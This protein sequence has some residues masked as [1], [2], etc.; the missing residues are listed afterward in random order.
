M[1]LRTRVAAVA[2]VGTVAG[3]AFT[4]VALADFPNF[5]DCPTSTDAPSCVDLQSTSGSLQVKNHRIDLG[6]SLEVRG[7]VAGD[8][9][10]VGPD[11]TSGLFSEPVEV[12]GGITGIAFP[13][14]LNR[15]TVELKVVEGGSVSFN[16]GTL[17]ITAPVN[18][19][20]KSP[21]LGSCSVGSKSD[22][23]QLDLTTGT[24]S[25]PAPNQPISGSTG[26][27]TFQDGYLEFDNASNVDNSFA[28]PGAK[29]CLANGL[30]NRALG[31]PSAAGNNTMVV[32][33][34]IAVTF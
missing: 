10:V 19:K 28:L 24:T 1:N 12:P 26:D 22:P 13:S 32:N 5:S 21:L 17:D 3:A 2:V 29:N 20:V 8:G 15:L 11:G 31:T 33:D 6:S 23:I 4:G 14:K 30:I 27:L 18:L 34:N 25:P 16:A 9:T 7:A